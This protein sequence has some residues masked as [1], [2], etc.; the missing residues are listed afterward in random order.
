MPLRI[1]KSHQFFLALLLIASFVFLSYVSLVIFRDFPLCMD[2]HG[3]SFQAHL[4]AKGHLYKEVSA[5]EWPLADRWMIFDKNRIFSHYPPGFPMVLAIGVL[6][7]IP[8]LVN[9]FLSVMTLFFIYKIVTTF[10]RPFIALGIVLLVAT[11]S[12]FIGYGASYFSQSLALTLVTMGLYL[13]RSYELSPQS[14]TAIALGLIIGFCVL[15]RQVDALCLFLITG[16]G[17]IFSSISNKRWSHL[18][19]IISFSLLGVLILGFYFSL[20]TG[21]FCLC[22]SQVWDR[23]CPFLHRSAGNF[24]QNI[25]LVISKY[26]QTFQ[27]IT[28]FLVRQKF[29]INL[30]I[31]FLMLAVGGLYSKIDKYFHYRCFICLLVFIILYGFEPYDDW[32]QYGERYYYPTLGAMAVLAAFALDRLGNTLPRYLLSLIFAVS[33]GC[34]LINV[35]RDLGFYSKRFSFE[36]TIIKD[37]HHHCPENSVVIIDYPSYEW[38]QVAPGFVSWVDF[39]KNFIPSESRL[40]VFNRPEADAVIKTHPQYTVCEYEL[41][42]T[43]HVAKKL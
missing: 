21:K 26:C 22:T 17:V 15:V 1:F 6:L 34:Q 42:S 5:N 23:D 20:L 33:I 43:F 32:S 37:L 8:G 7:G 13:Y 41:T 19:Y 11:N 38:W 18:V 14:N 24:W 29:M 10:V 28:V 12:Y 30:G 16:S 39:H 36:E 40:F 31:P 25:S 4:F 27:V 9:P 35:K 3:F 2:E